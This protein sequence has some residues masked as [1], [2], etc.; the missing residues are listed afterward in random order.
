MANDLLAM[1]K[2]KLHDE[3]PEGVILD[4]RGVNMLN[5]SGIGLL[6]EFYK[7]VIGQELIFIAITNN[8]VQRTL[9][10]IGFEG[11]FPMVDSRE[12]ALWMMQSEMSKKQVPS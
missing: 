5:S 12:E 3:E 6:I 1:A 11:V 9:G 4:L 2:P 7:E 8:Y 10:L